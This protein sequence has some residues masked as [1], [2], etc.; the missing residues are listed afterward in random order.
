MLIGVQ[1]AGLHQQLPQLL[2]SSG[3]G[4]VL[5]WME[6]ELLGQSPRTPLEAKLRR[7]RTIKTG[8]QYMC[9]LA[10][11]E[12]VKGEPNRKARE[13]ERE[14]NIY[15]Q[16]IQ[17]LRNFGEGCGSLGMFFVQD[18]FHLASPELPCLRNEGRNLEILE[19]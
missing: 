14:E 8:T 4:T 15:E 17:G 10:D 2:Y 7:I 9:G 5:F 6:C 19:D 11:S 16:F 1:E 13:R 12:E 3:G 18:I